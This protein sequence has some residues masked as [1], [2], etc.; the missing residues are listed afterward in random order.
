MEYIFLISGI[1]L[2]MTSSSWL[3]SMMAF[4]VIAMSVVM[5]LIGLSDLKRKP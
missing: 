3:S 2:L 5:I 4:L 1:G